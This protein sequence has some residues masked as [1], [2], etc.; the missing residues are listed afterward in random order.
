MN[1]RLITSAATLA[2]VTV[3]L[4]ADAQPR[5]RARGYGKDAP[6]R[7][8]AMDRNHDRVIARSEW[9]GSD[10]AFRLHD[11]D[12][13]GVLSGEEVRADSDG[14]VE[15]FVDLDTNNDGTIALN[16]WR[17]SR[18]AFERRDANADGRITRREFDTSGAVGTSG[19]HSTAYSAGYERGAQEGR[20]QAQEDK[21]RNQPYDVEGQRELETA[22]SGYD[23]RLGAKGDYQAGYRAGWRRGY[24]EGWRQP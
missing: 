14:R 5:G 13:D 22:D 11:W 4:P 15:R 2:L 18:Q 10:E 16:E 3:A 24:P 1:V 21:V 9:Q 17:R 7:F 12:G 20:A 23:V 8:E 19:S 6:I